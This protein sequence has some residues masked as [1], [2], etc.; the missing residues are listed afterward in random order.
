M[1]H[2][3]LLFLLTLALP[4]SAQRYAVVKAVRE[5][6]VIDSRWADDS[7]ATAFLAPYRHIV[8]SAMR[9]V[10]GQSARYMRSHGPESELSNLLSDIMVW[11]GKR[12]KERPDVGL[13]NFGG[14]RA[15]L[16]KGTVTFGDINDMAPFENKV[17]FITLTGEQLL[18]LFRELG[19][20]Y[21]SGVS[22]G[23]RAVYKGRELQSLEIGGK[24]VSPKR[25]YRIATID[26]LLHGNDGYTLLRQGSDIRSP[27]DKLSNTRFIIADYFREQAAQGKVVDARIEGRFTILPND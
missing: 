2:L 24:K 26:Y 27:Q 11:A 15:A 13:Y 1:K 7:A 5:A 23:V 25:K 22:A 9:P 10:V 6:V 4:V 16:P 8:D 19:H 17:C 12:Y 21:G 14:I 3:S 18:A 20:K